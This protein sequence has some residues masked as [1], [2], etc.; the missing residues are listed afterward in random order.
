MYT[1]IEVIPMKQETKGLRA[2][3]PYFLS[4]EAEGAYRE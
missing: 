3:K 4:L 1:A 2:E